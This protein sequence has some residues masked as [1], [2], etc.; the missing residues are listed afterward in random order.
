MKQKEAKRHS[1][2]RCE[3]KR[4]H[5]TAND[6]LNLKETFL[7]PGLKLVDL[8]RYSELRFFTYKINGIYIQI[9]I[10]SLSNIAL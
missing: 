4:G 2:S 3:R 10:L 7:I 6:L 9:A 1:L 8:C 5:S